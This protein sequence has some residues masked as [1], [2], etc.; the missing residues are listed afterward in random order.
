MNIVTI[1]AIEAIVEASVKG[2]TA[3]SVL[4][5]TPV[6]MVK[7]H[8]ETKEANPY[9]GAIKTQKKN[10]IIGFDYGN[11]VN[12]QAEREGLEKRET[13]GR[14]WGVLSASR[15]F[16]HHKGN[17]YLQL[18]VQSTTDTV[19]KLNGE[20]IS[21]DL[22]KPYLSAISKSSTQAGLEKEI[23]VNDIKMVNLKAVTMKGETYLLSNEEG[24]TQEKEAVAAVAETV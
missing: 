4:S 19:Y 21:Y 24:T 9:L 14:T 23:I 7:K 6:R 2:T 10:G 13:K 1:A 22:L 5:E 17:S 16:V 18:K 12:N 8:R 15:L 20:V 11:A 3:V